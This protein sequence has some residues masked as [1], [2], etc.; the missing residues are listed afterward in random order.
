MN[1]FVSF[2]EDYDVV[3]WIRALDVGK[4]QQEKSLS[5]DMSLNSTVCKIFI[6]GV[7]GPVTVD[8]TAEQIIE[9]LAAESDV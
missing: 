3:T 7:A 9:R 1:G 2:D 5:S 4:I 8:M 6:K